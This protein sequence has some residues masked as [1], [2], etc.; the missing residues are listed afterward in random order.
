MDDDSLG[1]DEDF[2]EKIDAVVD[3]VIVVVD[4]C[5][6]GYFHLIYFA[7]DNRLVALN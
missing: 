3:T 1:G 4:T 5:T 7:A 6:G 2:D